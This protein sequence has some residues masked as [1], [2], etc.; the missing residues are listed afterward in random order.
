MEGIFNLNTILLH[1]LN[2]VLLFIAL[3]FLLYKPVRKFMKKRSDEVAEEFASADNQL[4]A[5]EETKQQAEQQKRQAEQAALSARE[6]SIA[7]ARQQ[8]EKIY[9]DAEADAQRIREKAQEDAERMLKE[10]QEQAADKVG[11]M[12]VEMAEMLLRRTV[13]QQDHDRL[14]KEFFESVAVRHE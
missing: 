2:A 11:A 8:A 14:T 6:Q 12:A 7:A 1:M 9:Q 13:T 4:R 10:A 3:Y 5:A